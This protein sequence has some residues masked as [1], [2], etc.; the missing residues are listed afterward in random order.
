MSETW[1]MERQRQ[2]EKQKPDKNRTADL[3]SVRFN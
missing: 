1:K 3:K 2:D